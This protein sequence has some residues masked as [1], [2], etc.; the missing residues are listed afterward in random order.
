MAVPLSQQEFAELSGSSQPTVSRHVANGKLLVEPGPNGPGIDPDHPL[1]RA[2]IEK[3]AAQ[4]ERLANRK[5]PANGNKK[6]GFRKPRKQTKPKAQPAPQTTPDQPDNPETESTKSESSP[7]PE[8]TRGGYSQDLI[9]AATR[10]EELKTRLLQLK[11][12]KE[13]HEALV[14]TKK[15]VP[16]HLAERMLDRINDGLEENFRTFADRHSGPLASTA[17]APGKQLEIR[18]YLELEINESMSRLKK[19]LLIQI[20][21]LKTERGSE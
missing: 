10:Q 15:F 4:R 17:K 8:P 3:K 12:N 6:K 16:V 20:Q 2:F 19:V 11:A 1:A 18:E 7:K 21:K 14:R 5:Q 13:R 9:D